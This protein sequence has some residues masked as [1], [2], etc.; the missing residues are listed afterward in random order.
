[1]TDVLHTPDFITVPNDAP[2]EPTPHRAPLVC[3]I[4][5]FSL[6]A[7]LVLIKSPAMLEPDDFAY[8][9]SIVALSHGQIL[10]TNAQYHALSKELAANGGQG[11]LQWHHMASGRWISE[12]NP[13]YPF[14]AVLFYMIHALRLAP[15]FYGAAACVA[16]FVGARAWLGRWAG[17][18]AVWLYCL[19]G[20]ALTFAWRATMASFTDA[21]LVA[22][23]FGALLWVGLTPHATSRRR[24]IVGLVAFLALEGAV[25][26]RYTDAIELGVAV[27][28]TLALG[29]RVALSW[30]IIFTWMASVALFVVGV[31]AFDAWAYGKATSTG[32]SPGEITFALSSFWPNLKGMPRQLTTSMP[33]WLLA[34]ASLVWIIVG[35][36][37][38][39]ERV[40]SVAATAKRDAV[41]A[42]VLALGWLGLWVLYLNYTWTVSMVSGNGGPG[43]GVTVHVIRFY[44]PALGL[45]ALL[46]TWLLIRLRAWMTWTTLGALSLAGV[47]SFNSMASGGT[48]GGQ[49]G[50]GFGG[51]HGFPTLRGGPPS[52]VKGGG[53]AGGFRGSP[54]RGPS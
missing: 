22:M 13:G 38:S 28:A 37:R 33:M 54:P 27:L 14:F 46:G 11:I 39:R 51:H 20:A 49:P 34:A 50:G 3:A 53:P 4:V 23:G 52:K 42:G 43:G 40:D 41:V 1:M 5:G 31:L 29:R 35:L 19:S 24:L 15:L 44:I 36:V 18:Y 6:F 7:F 17:T 16:L 47:L 32:Y 25:F 9:A 10:L 26:I 21:S 8:R 12:K 48:V 30:R 45:I 2:I